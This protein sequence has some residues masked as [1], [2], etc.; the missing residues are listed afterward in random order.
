[1]NEVYLNLVDVIGQETVEVRFDSR[2]SFRE[3]FALLKQMLGRD[4]ENA[5][6]YDPDKKI[7]LDR[8]ISLAEYGFSG[9]V[10]L[11]LFYSG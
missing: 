1:M 5:D 9:F 2:L 10:C 4:Y 11:H 8:N 6:V 7:F 3:N